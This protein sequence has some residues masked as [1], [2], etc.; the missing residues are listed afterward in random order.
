MR[1]LYLGYF[2]PEKMNARQDRD[3]CR[4]AGSHPPWRSSGQV[5]VDGGLARETK[6]SG[7]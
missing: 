7:V 5:I 3:R 4:H 1:F 2:D 6:A